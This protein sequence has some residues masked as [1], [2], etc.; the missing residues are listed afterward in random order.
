MRLEAGSV[1][2]PIFGKVLS[3][4]R[5]RKHI[6]CAFCYIL[7]YNTATLSKLALLVESAMLMGGPPV[8]CVC[9]FTPLSILL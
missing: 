5:I 7:L 9:V 8:R 4:I 1:S 6:Y 2:E 3:M